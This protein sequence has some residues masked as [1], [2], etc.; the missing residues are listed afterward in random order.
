MPSNQRR[1][2]QLPTEIA[3]NIFTSLDAKSLHSVSLTN[4]RLQELANTPYLWRNLC[5][6]C[7]RSWNPELNK[8]LPQLPVSSTDYYK[9]RYGDRYSIDLEVRQCLD[10]LVRQQWGRIGAIEEISTYGFDAKDELLRL[11]HGTPLDDDHFLAKT[12]WSRVILERMHREKAVQTWQ[13]IPA[14]DFEHIVD[15]LGSYDLFLFDGDGYEELEHIQ[16]R[17]ADLEKAFVEENPSYTSWSVRGIA[18]AL[19]KFLSSRELMGM[20][21]PDASYHLLR[22]SFIG[23]ALK[24]PAH[25][26][27]PLICSSIYVILARKLGLTAWPCA[28]PTHIYVRVDA[29]PFDLDTAPGT[30][31]GSTISDLI[32]HTLALENINSKQTMFLDVFRHDQEVPIR[33]LHT[34]L[35]AFGVVGSEDARDRYFRPMS[36]WDLA[37]RTRRNIERSIAVSRTIPATDSLPYTP[38]ARRPPSWSPL[39]P[40]NDDANYAAVWANVAI[41]LT[42]RQEGVRIQDLHS[43]LSLLCE[44]IEWQY[45]WDIDILEKY[46]A[47]HIFKDFILK[48]TAAMRRNDA[49]RPMSKLRVLPNGD[50]LP[51]S[52]N[53]GQIMRHRR[54]GYQGVIIGWDACDI[55][56]PSGVQV[57]AE[58]QY[59]SA[60]GVAFYEVVADDKTIRYIAQENIVP[61][62]PDEPPSWNLMNVA[63][64]WF[65]R[66]DP[67]SNSFVSNLEQEYPDR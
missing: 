39:M 16:A 36:T 28:F 59:H 47:P 9:K 55:P 53:I 15:A 8:D 27:L 7:Y 63:G 31:D 13:S 58:D 25:R 65:K 42:T 34:Q 43:I 26:S 32:N 10:H 62:Q 1:L 21:D 67:F 46:A 3:C 50:V 64:R 38:G 24:S 18:L 33:Q 4:H 49:R 56:S 20:G 48:K 54:Y 30:L 57:M 60:R 44:T 41:G 19:S 37:I 40:E 66:Y 11:Y 5:R 35:A 22:N 61:V 52:F 51:V 14:T 45:P 23:L 6:S 29:Q 12:Y 2:D 17:L